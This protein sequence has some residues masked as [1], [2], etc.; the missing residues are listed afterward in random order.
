VLGGAEPS[1]GVVQVR[2][3]AKLPDALLEIRIVP[4]A[5]PVRSRYFWMCCCS[6]VRH[7]ARLAQWE[8]SWTSDQYVRLP[9][10]PRAL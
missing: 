3:S 1:V 9:C 10:T 5:V 6:G 4:A 8:P 2:H 7:S